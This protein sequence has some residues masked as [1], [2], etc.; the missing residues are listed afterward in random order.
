MVR[1]AGVGMVGIMQGGA[2][3]I[4]H[5]EFLDERARKLPRRKRDVHYLCKSDT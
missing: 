1:V 2:K 5:R 4:A 3:L